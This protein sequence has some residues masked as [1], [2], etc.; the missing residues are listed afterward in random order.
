MKLNLSNEPTKFLS[1]SFTEQIISL[2]DVLLAEVIPP[3]GQTKLDLIHTN[4][5]IRI[6][7]EQLRDSQ[8]YL[9]SHLGA[10]LHPKGLHPKT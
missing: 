5:Y 10:G 4:H 1:Y 3:C 7:V 8:K 2:E 6:T 9:T